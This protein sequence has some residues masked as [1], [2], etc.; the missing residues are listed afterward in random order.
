MYIISGTGQD[1]LLSFD[2]LL[3]FPS[4]SIISIHA[5]K[6]IGGGRLGTECHLS[7]ALPTS[8]DVLVTAGR[9][10]DDG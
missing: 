1:C 6:N 5:Y 9:P 7:Q 10:P 2:D 8:R 4:I 3:S